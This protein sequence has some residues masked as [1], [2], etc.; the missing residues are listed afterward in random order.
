MN[1]A[2]QPT[3]SHSSAE[4]EYRGVA[5]A[6]AE[7]CWLRNLL[8][9]L[10]AH[11]SSATLVYC[12]NHM[13]L[14][15]DEMTLMITNKTTL[16]NRQGPE[17]RISALDLNPLESSPDISPVDSGQN[18]QKWISLRQPT[19]SRSSAEAE[20]RGVA[21]AVAETC[22][23]RNLLRELFTH[24]S[25]AML[26]YCNN[27]SAIYLSANPVQH[28]RTKH[29]E[30]YIHFIGDLIAAHQVRVRHVPS[31]YHRFY[32]TVASVVICGLA[33]GLIGGNCWKMVVDSMSNVPNPLTSKA[34]PRSFGC[35]NGLAVVDEKFKVY[36]VNVFSC[37]GGFV[38]GLSLKLDA[39]SRKYSLLN[40]LQPKFIGFELLKQEYPDPDFGALFLNCE[41]T[42]NHAMGDFHISSG[43]LFKQQR[44]CVPRHTIQ[45]VLIQETHE[46]GLA[47]EDDRQGP[48]YPISALDLN[49]PESSPD[50][51][52]VDSGQN[53]QKWI[54]L[55]QL[56]SLKM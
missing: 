47:G 7:T 2:R 34:F 23:L 53:L 31:R 1:F 55:V 36:W 6:V 35:F 28:Q 56:D 10:Y 45:L 16:I 32:V 33:D 37:D 19:L 11:L 8:R 22:W 54:S 3:L 46:G 52:P 30:I 43:F 12:N 9:E 4:A 50:I 13:V 51:S 27:V 18:M 38:C 24:L 15:I 48:E 49:P 25:S 41:K 17:Y 39:L 20:Y 29:I 44:L 14:G 5:N 40:H 26:V 42:H 21:N